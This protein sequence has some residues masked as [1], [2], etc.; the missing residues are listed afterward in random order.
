MTKRQ[1]AILEAVKC[2]YVPYIW[3]GDDP[4]KGLDCSGFIGHILRM[5]GLMPAGS[6]DTAQGYINKYHRFAAATTREGCLVFYGK[7]PAKITHVM[8]AVTPTVC[9]GAV[10]GNKWVDT[11]LRAKSRNAK[12]DVRA[13]DYR[14]DIV[15]I[16]DPFMEEENGTD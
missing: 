5:V 11:V 8:M 13:I 3:G 1:Q 16:V 12:V 4:D 2:L 14:K 15:L 7:G 10:R 6:D 9:I